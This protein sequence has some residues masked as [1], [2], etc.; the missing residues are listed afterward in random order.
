MGDEPL[1]TKHQ[2]RLCGFRLKSGFIKLMN[3]RQVCTRDPVK[4]GCFNEDRS[5]GRGG[6]EPRCQ[7]P[8]S[9]SASLPL[10]GTMAGSRSLT[11][12]LIICAFCW[13]RGRTLPGP[14]Q[15]GGRPNWKRGTGPGRRLCRDRRHLVTLQPQRRAPRGVNQLIAEEL[16]RSQLRQSHGG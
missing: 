10:E 6:R 13:E 14:Q 16:T 4:D 12:V 11:R 2:E 9:G 15:V 1:G 7:A 8:S 3:T 5:W